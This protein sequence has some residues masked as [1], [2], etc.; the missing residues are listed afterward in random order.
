[1]ISQIRSRLTLENLSFFLVAIAVCGITFFNR[2]FAKI[3]VGPLYI[4]EVLF[5]GA[6]FTTLPTL[7]DFLRSSWK[8]L[9][10]VFA[11]FAWGLIGASYQWLTHPGLSS[12]ETQR[13]LQHT[14][15]F[16]YP[17]MWLTCGLWLWWKNPIKTT[18]LIYAIIFFN[19]LPFVI[20]GQINHNIAQGPFL[21][22]VM[23]WYVFNLHRWSTSPLIKWGMLVGGYTLLFFPFWRMWMTTMQRTTLIYLLGVLILSP[24]VLSFKSR[25]FGRAAAVITLTMAFL[26]SG[27]LIGSRLKAPELKLSQGVSSQFLETMQ[28][29]EDI[30]IESDTSTFQARFRRSC[31]MMA[32]RDWKTNPTWGVG[33]IPEVPKYLYEGILNDGN[34]EYEG[35]PPVSG[36]H[37]S[38]LSVLARMG[39]MGSIVFSFLILQIVW[40]WIGYFLKPRTSL[41]SLYLFF[42]PPLFAVTALFHVVFE[43]P[44]NSI[45]GWLTCGILIGTQNLGKK[46]IS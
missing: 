16:I 6:F 23:A 22:F 25:K 27:M 40:A 17:M 18:R 37:N 24:I 2:S 44:H 43:S 46:I 1:M 7:K 12:F 26:F 20:Q 31:W 9:L 45:I 10:P 33:F 34:L 38:Y 32:I 5:L 8:Q 29:Q 11:F 14:L 3:Q 35:A 41:F 4:L 39:I 21:A 30:P 15:L 19:I 42:V 36:P 13:F 28:H